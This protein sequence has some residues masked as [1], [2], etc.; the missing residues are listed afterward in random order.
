[1]S[2]RITINYEKKPCYYIV[3][4]KSFDSLGDELEKLNIYERKICIITDSTVAKLYAEPI[5]QLLEGKCKKIILHISPN[6]LIFY[7]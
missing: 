5:M 1:M 3:F 2:E 7:P 4:S 6:N